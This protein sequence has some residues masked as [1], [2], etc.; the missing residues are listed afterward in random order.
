MKRVSKYYRKYKSRRNK[1][2]FLNIAKITAFITSLVVSLSLSF[3]GVKNLISS[4]SQKEVLEDQIEQDILQGVDI[5]NTYN[6]YD[7]IQQAKLEKKR[8]EENKKEIIKQPE[9]DDLETE[10]LEENESVEEQESYFIDT[11]LLDA[12]YE[13]KDVD[14][15]SYLEENEDVVGW[16]TLDGTPIDYPILQDNDNEY[17]LHHDINGNYSTD[18]SI[19]LDANNEILA[20]PTEELYDI[21]FIYGHHMADDDMFAS[22]CNYKRQS[23]ADKN[24]FFVIY[25]PDGYAYKCDVFAGVLCDGTDTQIYN[26]YQFS[27]QKNFEE[28]MDYITQNSKIS[29]DVEVSYDDK[30]VALVTCSYEDGIDGNLRYVVF[31]KMTKQYIEEPEE[32]QAR[33]IR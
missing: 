18:G 15:D 10:Q 23:F 24:P 33:L 27:S 9:T 31:A 12:G 22:I 16:I 14:F 32:E 7:V 5:E 2:I 26:Y 25:T 11:E 28:Y 21:N 6:A 20:N 13:F 19:F 3:H 30:I 29:T 17:Y 8:Q 4:L 1:L